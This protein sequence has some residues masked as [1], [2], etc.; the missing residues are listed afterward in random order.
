VRRKREAKDGRLETNADKRVEDGSS[1]VRVWLMGQHE[2]H[3]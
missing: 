2:W 1:K 3:C